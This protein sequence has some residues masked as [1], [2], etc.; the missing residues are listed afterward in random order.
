MQ[1]RK[2]VEALLGCRIPDDLY[3]EALESASKKQEYIYEREKRVE[4]LQDWYLVQLIA[5]YIRSK[6]FSQLTMHICR[7]MFNMEKEHSTRSQSAQTDNHIVSI[8]A[9]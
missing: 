7:K 2:E 8:P 3:E 4:V 1:Q 9:L 6:S 5:E